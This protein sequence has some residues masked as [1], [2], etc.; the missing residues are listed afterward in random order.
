MGNNHTLQKLIDAGANLDIQNNDGWTALMD[1]AHRSHFEIVQALIAA[2]ANL[3][4]QNNDG[5]YAYEL[6]VPT[7]NLFTCISTRNTMNRLR[8]IS[9]KRDYSKLE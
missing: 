7:F 1:A 5:K 2:G 9:F 8:G 6:Y 4:I 3:D